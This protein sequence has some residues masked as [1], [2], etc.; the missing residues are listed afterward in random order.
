MICKDMFERAVDN[1]TKKMCFGFNKESLVK[2]VAKDM[3]MCEGEKVEEESEKM[4]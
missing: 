4:K 1:V 2:I 3:I